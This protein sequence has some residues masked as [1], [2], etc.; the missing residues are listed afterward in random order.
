VRK[1]GMSANRVEGRAPGGWRASGFSTESSM[2]AVFVTFNSD[3]FDEA[4]VRKVAE[5]V[6]GKFEGLANLRNK[7]FT[8]DEK[9]YHARNV[10][11]WD[12]EDA[13][14]QF[15]SDELLERVT[16]LYG[17]RPQ[18]EFAEVLELVDNSS[19]PSTR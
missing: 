19:V 12:S 9:K 3:S 5:D 17:V 8:L 18:I 16:G 13:A 2:I 11:V 6:K 7:F 4:R 10:Y 14:R 15:F 1:E